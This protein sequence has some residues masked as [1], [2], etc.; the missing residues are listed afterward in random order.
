MSLL[1]NLGNSI[2]AGTDP[3]QFYNFRERVLADGATVLSDTQVSDEIKR[4]RSLGLYSKFSAL[5]TPAVRNTSKLYSIISADGDATVTR[6][7]VK[8]I[9]T[10]TGTLEE[11]ASDVTPSS[12]GTGGWGALVEGARTNFALQ[13]Q[14]FGTTWTNT[15]TTESLDSAIAPDGTTTADKLEEDTSTGGHVITQNGIAGATGDGA[16]TFS[17]FVKAVERTFVRLEQTGNASGNSGSRAVFNLTTGVVS[18]TTNIGSP[19]GTGV[20]RITAFPN[21]WYRCEF[22]VTPATTGNTTRNVS[23]SLGTD[24]TTFSY[25]G[26]LGSGVL[27]WGAQLEV[28]SFASSY[29]KTEGATFTRNADV[30]TKTGA[31]DLI[32]QTEGTLYA[33]V[34]AR[35]L[36]LSI[37]RSVLFLSDG[38]STNIVRLQYQFTGGRYVLVSSVIRS[39]SSGW[40]KVATTGLNVVNGLIKIA[41]SYKSGSVEVY[42][43]GAILTGTVTGDGTFT[44]FSNIGNINIGSAFNN[45]TQFNDRILLA[46]IS[47][48][49][50]TQAEAI[51]LTT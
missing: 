15:G 7:S 5:Y 46:G 13:S 2:T 16:Y 31:S 33:V 48:T 17:C 42:Q 37:S 22:T 40:E 43:N 39:G 8:N 11:I 14:N 30:I 38:T 47:K 21:G 3:Y 12:F 27:L 18:S 41:L 50:L 25:T 4:L 29:M 24:A 10:A 26:V 1:L 34:D 51:A 49:A 32:G 6:G 28:G 19:A 9:N 36:P 44:S 20:A 35:N 45:E 23:I